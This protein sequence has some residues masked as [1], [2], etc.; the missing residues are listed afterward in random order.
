MSIFESLFNPII[1]IKKLAVLL[2]L[3]FS[4]LAFAQ[5]QQMAFDYFRKG[6][7]EKAASIYQSLYDQNNFNSNYLTRL[8]YC[9]QQLEQFEISEELIE[10]HL[11]SNPSQIQFLVELGYN[12]QLQHQQ[13]EATSYYTKAIARVNKD[14]IYG[15]TVGRTFQKN[16]LLD[17]ALEAYTIALKANPESNYELQIAAIHAE[18]GNIE[19]L[20]NTYL[21]LIEKDDRYTPTV[22]R[23]AG[24]YITDDAESEYNLVFK[25]AVLQRLQKN[26]KNAWN[27][28]LSWLFIQQADYNKALIQEKALYKRMDTLGLKRIIN[29]GKI[30]FEQ[31]QLDVTKTAFDFVLNESSDQEEI[32]NAKLY[33]LYVLVETEPNTTLI[34]DE[35]EN[36]LSDYGINSNTLNIQIA[37]AD[38]LTFK[39]NNATK[40]IQ[41]L[42]EALRLR[43]NDFQKGAI[44]LKLGDVLVFNGQ[45]NQA[46]IYYSQVQTKLKNHVLG[47]Q[48][49]FKVAQTSYFKGD[50]DWANTQLK[51]LKGS[52]SQLIANDALRLSLII[53]DNTVQ[54]SLKTALKIYAKADLLAYQ[55]KNDDAILLLDQ[56][57]TEH[58]GHAL[59]DETLLK[60]GE[61]FEEQNQHGKAE[62]NYLKIIDLNPTDIL[63]DN[64]CFKLGQLY[65]KINE[66]EKAKEYY[67][68]IIFE[69]PSSIYLVEARKRFRILRG[70]EI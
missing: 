40:A 10:N 56:I 50:F 47:Q 3:C 69:Y 44:K 66:I 29:L 13:D 59:E 54:D 53:N 57:L 48:A 70:D 12:H 32:V 45:F 49:Q 19:Q 4:S 18:K 16:H 67:Q 64:A 1:L 26:S 17:Y 33:L 20:F 52:T 39:S 6:E 15:Y 46:L 21:D 27:E 11:R 41:V 60:Q 22:Q 37:Y 43:S 5:E 34:T 24:K 55:N 51:V 62:S 25:K 8:I 38:F 42:E 68:K 14:H 31:K 9:Y 35:F 63:V 58:K 2:F 65:E 7:F 28:L 23:Y 61:L 36:L 30:S